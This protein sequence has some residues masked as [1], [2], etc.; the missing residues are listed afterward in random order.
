M[1]Y[2]D[3][4]SIWLKERHEEALQALTSSFYKDI[5]TYMMRLR[6]DAR[7]VEKDTTR[8]RIVTAEKENVER[9]VEDLFDIRLRKIVSFVHDGKEVNMDA[10]T[11]E[12]K[13]FST[14]LK[15][16]VNEH[17]EILKSILK[18][19]VEEV[20]AK[21]KATGLKVIRVLTDIPAIIGI[22]LATYGPYKAED[23]AAL[24][25]EN[26]ESLIKRGLAVEVEE[27]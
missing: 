18:G 4:M 22:D 5:A 16:V 26:A 19:R 3:L 10:L 27:E 9:M 1:S 14:E 21:P 11:A 23:V 25:S 13:S 2:A 12:E 20:K 24:P 17:L 15:K 6:E 7:M 8:S